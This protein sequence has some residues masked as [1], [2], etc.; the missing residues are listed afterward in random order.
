M[1]NI[2]ELNIEAKEYYKKGQYDEYRNNYHFEPPFGLLNDPNG[3]SY[4]N[5]EYHLFF[6]WN[7]Y[8]CEHKFKHWG[9]IRTKD[10]KKFTIPKLMMAPND[11]YDK[12]GCYSGCGVVVGDNLELFYTGNVKDENDNRKVYQCRAT[13]DKDGNFIKKGP[14]IDKVADGYTAHFRDPYVYKKDDKYIMIIGTQTKEEKGRAV[15]YT[16]Y[17]LEKWTFEGEMKTRYE[18]FGYMWECPNMIKIDSKDVFVFSPQGLKKEEFRYQNIYQSGY[19]MGKFNE[20]SLEF[21]HD[22]FEELDMGFDFYAPQ[23]F[24]DDKNRNILIGWMGLPEEEKNH[25]SNRYNWVHSLTMPRELSIRNNKLYQFP[26]KEIQDLKEEKLFDLQDEKLDNI[27]IN[28]ICENSYL[29]SLKLNK[30]NA[31]T[32]SLKFMLNKEEYMLLEVNFKDSIGKLHRVGK[33]SEVRKFK[34][35]KFKTNR[36]DDLKIDIFVDKSA[37]EIYLQD[38]EIAL[39]SRVYASKDAKNIELNCD[40]KIKIDSFEIHRLGKVT[41]NE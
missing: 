20:Y 3:L 29:L 25:D 37:V 17:D 7:P 21:D 16:S 32:M 6:Q 27:Q 5:G 34:I 13:L 8:T 15:V 12:N 26:I 23:V 22:E 19:M 18:D 1:K 31:K 14:V 30:E 10:F 36:S 38:G 4:Y 11:Y 35:D 2:N 33:I 39:S 9:L 28:N 40:N 24:K 41:Y